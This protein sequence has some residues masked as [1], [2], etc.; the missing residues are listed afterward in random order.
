MLELI[1]SHVNRN[2]GRKESDEDPFELVEKDL[3]PRRLERHIEMQR[4]VDAC[5]ESE[6]AALEDVEGA[7]GAGAVDPCYILLFGRIVFER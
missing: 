7:S 2:L 6:N 1:R 5:D 3:V 4:R